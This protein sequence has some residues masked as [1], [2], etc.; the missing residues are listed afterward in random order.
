MRHLQEVV[1]SRM[2]QEMLGGSGEATGDVP[3]GAVPDEQADLVLS[4][5]ERTRDDLETGAVARVTP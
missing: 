3:T 5:L 1:C 2:L 4:S